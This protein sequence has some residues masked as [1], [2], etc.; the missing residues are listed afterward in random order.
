MS[1]IFNEEIF[2]L[3]YLILSFLSSESILCNV[4][5]RTCITKNTIESSALLLNAESTMNVDI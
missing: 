4:L 5:F 2:F 1:F 3:L